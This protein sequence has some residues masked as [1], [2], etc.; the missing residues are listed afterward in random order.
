MAYKMSPNTKL[1]VSI[2]VIFAIIIPVLLAYVLIFPLG[3]S[4][5]RTV[6]SSSS[7]TS[8]T[9]AGGAPQVIIPTGIGSNQQLNFQ[10]ITLTVAA[11]TTIVFVNQ[12]TSIHDIDFTSLPSG[13]SLATNPS[14]NTNT[15]TNGMYNVTLSSPGTYT[16]VCDY[17][18][19]MKG[20]ITV[21]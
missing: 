6:A 17:H 21:T 2:V 12:D 5:T 4:P 9:S 15:W 19:W 8:S 7:I 14:P 11:G 13:V 10:P 16:Y 1:V 3:L 18:T 20:T